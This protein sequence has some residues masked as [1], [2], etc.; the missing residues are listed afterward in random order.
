[1][2]FR[3]DCVAKEPPSLDN[4]N[5]SVDSLC[6][7]YSVRKIRCFLEHQMYD[8]DVVLRILFLMP[9][10]YIDCLEFLKYTPFVEDRKY[11]NC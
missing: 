3:G 10:Y 11:W 2:L 8:Y 7:S 6:G 1:M 5:L 9:S 4:S